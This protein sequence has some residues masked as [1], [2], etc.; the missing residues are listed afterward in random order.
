[1]HHPSTIKNSSLRE[2]NHAI[3]EIRDPEDKSI[4][5]HML[6]VVKALEVGANVDRLVKC[7]GYRRDYIEG[8]SL[9]MRKAELWVGELVDDREWWDHRSD[10][11]PGI[12]WHGLV[13]QGVLNRV[14]NPN[15]GC[16]YLDAETGEVSGEWNPPSRKVS[17]QPS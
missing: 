3:E 10:P 17:H 12:F 11:S 4:A 6:V 7:T 5:E 8:I 15:G 14:P 16:T 9:R 1:M 2:L 13:A